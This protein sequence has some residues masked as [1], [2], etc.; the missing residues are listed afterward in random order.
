ME[1]LMKSTKISC[2]PILMAI[3]VLISGKTNANPVRQQKPA[4][5]VTKV[6]CPADVKANESLT[7]TAE[8]NGGDRN[9]VPTYNW[10]V[11]AGT[12]QSGQG[13]RT[14]K[15]DTSGLDADSTI[16]ATVEAGGF[17][18]ACGYGATVNSCTSAVL[19]RA[20]ARKLSEYTKT[21]Q[22]EEEARLDMFVIE[23]QNDPTT[24]GYILS[25]H[26]R[27]NRPGEAQ[28]A[29][30]KAA[31]YIIRKRGVEAN[32]VVTVTGGSREQTTVELWIVP[33]GAQPPKPTA[34]TKR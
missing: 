32:R 4:C 13:T 29:A 25:Y 8:V 17:D 19:K 26:P 34:E 2:Y 3:A 12:I 30:D 11:S 10:T 16:T 23:L 28:K 9:V 20:E 7:F 18:R 24:Q 22:K 31:A 14:I 27:P 5:P 15:V 21:T 6:T 33:T 1:S